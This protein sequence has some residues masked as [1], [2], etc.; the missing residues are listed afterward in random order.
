M[1]K[2]MLTHLELSIV[3]YLRDLG[4]GLSEDTESTTCTMLRSQRKDYTA[5]PLGLHA[6]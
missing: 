5:P 3:T 1:Q 4:V 6:Q 2:Q